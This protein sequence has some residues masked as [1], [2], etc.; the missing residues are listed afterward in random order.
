MLEDGK[1][2]RRTF[3]PEVDATAARFV[4][5]VGVVALGFGR[6]VAGGRIAGPDKSAGPGKLQNGAG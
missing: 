5:A 4:P 3:A 1:T 2:A 6:A